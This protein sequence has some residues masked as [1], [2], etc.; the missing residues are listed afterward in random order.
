MKHHH[1]IKAYLMC[2][3]AYPSMRFALI[4]FVSTGATTAGLL[5]FRGTMGA[6]LELELEL[7]LDFCF[8]YH[9]NLCI[10]IRTYTLIHLQRKLPRAWRSG[11]CRS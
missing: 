10:D 8:C 1:Y 5:G 9:I 4:S 2:D 6:C 11:S 7:E 3:T